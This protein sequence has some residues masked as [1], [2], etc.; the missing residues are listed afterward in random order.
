MFSCVG[1]VSFILYKEVMYYRVLV[2]MDLLIGLENCIVM[3]VELE[4]YC[5]SGGF[6]FF[7]FDLNGFK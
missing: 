7:L 2:L 5:C 6:F 1:L 3:F 4:C